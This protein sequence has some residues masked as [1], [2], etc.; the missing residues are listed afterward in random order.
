M[1]TPAH[2]CPDYGAF[3]PDS[4]SCENALHQMLVW[5]YENPP[6]WAV[7]HL[8]V[9]CYYLQHPRLYSPAG[10]TDAQQILTAFVVQGV[11][12]EEIL[13]RNRAALDSGKR[14]W[15]ITGTATVYG[16]YQYPLRWPMTAA[17]VL[18]GGVNNYCDNVCAWAES[19]H[20]TL[21][22]SGNLAAGGHYAV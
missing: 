13:R 11:P 7:H 21:R 14:D 5:E 20:A 2:V 9:L 18:V 17:D 4:A 8:L 16:T 6:L 19:I 10:L 1:S 12:P 3:W 22:A 15:K